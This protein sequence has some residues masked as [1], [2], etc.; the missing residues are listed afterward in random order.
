MEENSN[1][2]VSGLIHWFIIIAAIITTTSSFFITKTTIGPQLVKH[3]RDI[4]KRLR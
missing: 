2:L 3:K 4:K 1:K